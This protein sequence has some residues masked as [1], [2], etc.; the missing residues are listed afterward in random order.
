M[1]QTL[2]IFGSIAMASVAILCVTLAIVAVRAGK[3]LERITATME[4]MGT[5]VSQLRERAIPLIEEATV[6]MQRADDTLERIDNGIA[7]LS[8]GTEAFAA[9]VSD[10]RDL[11][12][13]V[14]ATVR[15]PLEDVAS[16]LGGTVSKVTGFIKNFLDR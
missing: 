12:R 6:V 8:K 2:I 14:L 5:D 10:V 11:E 15:G 3:N 4:T 13:D 1:D 9:I 7:Q 16:L